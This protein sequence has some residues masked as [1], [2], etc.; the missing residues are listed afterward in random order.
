MH[1]TDKMPRVK[2][3]DLE[4]KVLVKNYGKG[5]YKGSREKEENNFIVTTSSLY[6]EEKGE[7]LEK[8]LNF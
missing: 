7:I 2:N 6:L 4:M 1:F 8:W 5:V 3:R